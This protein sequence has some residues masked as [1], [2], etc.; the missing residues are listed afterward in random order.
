MPSSN[1]A[2]NNNPPSHSDARFSLPWMTR[3]QRTRKSDV[4]AGAEVS[5]GK[6][7]TATP[8]ASAPSDLHVHDAGGDYAGDPA[9]SSH[10]LR[11]QPQQGQQRQERQEDKDLLEAEAEADTHLKEMSRILPVLMV[12]V[13]K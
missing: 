7:V 1:N 11:G 10:N 5:S 9:T 2:K 6:R 12:R 3:K 8:D 4:G 13:I